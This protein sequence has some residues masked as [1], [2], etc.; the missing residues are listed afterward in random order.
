MRPIIDMIE[1]LAREINNRYNEREREKG[2]LK[3]ITEWEDLPD[4]KKYSNV[5]AARDIIAKLGLVNCTTEDN[6]TT[7]ISSFTEQEIEILARFEHDQWVAERIRTGWVYGPSK[8][9]EKK[10]TPYLIPYDMLPE[11][12]KDKDRDPGRDI[13]ELLDLIGLKVYRR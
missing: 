7:P 5:R 9:N 10:I 2:D 3:N 12:V 6:G 11:D 13:I 8:I 4:T 1:I